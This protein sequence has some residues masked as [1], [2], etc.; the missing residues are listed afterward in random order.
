MLAPDAVKVYQGSQ[1][2]DAILLASQMLNEPSDFLN[3]IGR[4]NG[5]TSMSVVCVTP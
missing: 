1:E 4:A 3:Q 2:R 5:S